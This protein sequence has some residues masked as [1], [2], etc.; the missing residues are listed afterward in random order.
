MLYFYTTT[1]IIQPF[2]NTAYFSSY[3]NY[4]IFVEFA[5]IKLMHMCHRPHRNIEFSQSYYSFPFFL[6]AYYII[7]LYN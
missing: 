4:N 2:Y 7:I 1:F 6:I 5:N 3:N